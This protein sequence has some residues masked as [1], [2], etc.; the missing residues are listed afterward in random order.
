M[1][2]L[3][4]ETDDDDFVGR[5]LEELISA[6]IPC[7]RWGPATAGDGSFRGRTGATAGIYIERDGDYAAANEILV[8]LG[9]AQEKPLRLPA[10]WVARMVLI[11]F[12]LALVAGM[13]FLFT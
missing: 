2:L 8:K 11:L 1:A 6:G 5:A 13:L 10:S 4:Y 9:A 7:Y 12:L 3:V